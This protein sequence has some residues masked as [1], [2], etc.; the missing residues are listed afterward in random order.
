VIQ[1]HFEANFESWRIVARDYLSRGVA[2]HLLDWGGLSGSLF[3]RETRAIEEPKR[4][5]KPLLV[6]QKFLRLAPTVSMARDPDRWDLLYRLLYR[7]QFEN[8]NLLNI[9]VDKDVH[10]A[11]NLSKSIGRD[12]HKMHAFVRFKEIQTPQGEG[13]VAWHKPEHRILPA[14]SQFF[15]RRF[16]DKPWSI[17]TPDDS[18]HWDTKTLNFGPGIP[19]HEFTAKDEWDDIWVTYYKS[20]FNPARIKMK[21]MKSEMAPKYWS[22]LPEA[23]VIYDLLRDAPQKLQNM[24]TQKRVS[25]EVQPNWD[26]A[27]LKEKSKACVACPLYKDATQVVFGEG[28]TNASLMIVGEQPGD[29]EDQNGRVF[30]GPSGKL[31]DKVLAGLGVH[32]ESLYLTNS[33]KHFK[34][35]KKGKLR[36]HQTASGTEMHACRPWLIAEIAQVQP[37]VLLLL[38]KTASISVRGKF[39]NLKQVRGQVLVDNPSADFVISTWHPS[40]ILRESDGPRKDQKLQEFRADLLEAVRLRQYQKPQ[41]SKAPA[42]LPPAPQETSPH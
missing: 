40:A 14:A 19:Q 3:D 42:P 13:Y 30:S 8:K 18:A 25:A 10:R 15:V 23:E 27:D 29:Q 9:N 39:E 38:G 33:V 21:M 6:P 31:L 41:E 28:P 22:S 12:I 26:L 7:I 24:S 36:I 16:G 37:R 11:L 4:P 17:F 2:P 32:R 35:K 34:F 1:P 5:G 20:I